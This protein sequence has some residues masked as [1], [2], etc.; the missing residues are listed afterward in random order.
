MGVWGC[1]EWRKSAP[2][3]HSVGVD[4]SE[5]FPSIALY[6]SPLTFI[7]H[8]LILEVDSLP[9]ARSCYSSTLSSLPCTPPPP[10]FLLFCKHRSYSSSTLLLLPVHSRSRRIH[11]L[12]FYVSF[13]RHRFATLTKLPHRKRG[14]LPERSRLLHH[15][16]FTYYLFKLWTGFHTVNLSYHT[17]VR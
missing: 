6:A 14:S 1:V 11:S 16:T 4:V 13:H 5:P 12:Q 3:G 15:S 10:N 7:A 2:L 8:L 9:L 17:P